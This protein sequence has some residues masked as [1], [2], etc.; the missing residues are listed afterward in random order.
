MP[1]VIQRNQMFTTDSSQKSP[2]TLT[3]AIGVTSLLMFVVSQVFLHASTSGG[4]LI[5]IFAIIGLPTGIGFLLVRWIRKPLDS[6]QKVATVILKVATA[7]V[8]CLAGLL[9]AIALVFASGSAA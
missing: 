3:D 6:N 5:L 4:L 9:I 2:I 1:A 8:S 7:S